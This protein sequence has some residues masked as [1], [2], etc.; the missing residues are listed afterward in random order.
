MGQRA[1]FIDH[2]PRR[3][4]VQSQEVRPQKSERTVR[5]RREFGADLSSFAL[6]WTLTL[7]PGNGHWAKMIAFVVALTALTMTISSAAGA[8]CQFDG[9]MRII[10]LRRIIRAC[11]I[12]GLVVLGLN[13]MLEDQIGRV[14]SVVGSALAAVFAVCGRAIL[15][16][17]TSAR[18]AGVPSARVVLIADDEDGMFDLLDEY[19]AAGFHVVACLGR[20]QTSAHTRGLPWKGT[21][22]NIVD[23]VDECGATSVVLAPNRLCV[24]Y[25]HEQLPILRRRGVTVHFFSGLKG[26]HYRQLRTA[27]IG[28]DPFL[29]LEEPRFERCQ[30]ALKRCLDILLGSILLGLA[31]PVILLA[32]AAIKLEDAGPILF[33]QQR[34]GLNG[35]PFR[36]C[37]LRT[38]HC[39]AEA[40][41]LELRHLN[42]RDGGPLFKMT[43]DPRVTK[44]GCFLRATSID[45]L[46]QL[47]CVLRGDM[48]LVGPRPALPDE[49]VVFDHR[50]AE[51]QRVRPGVTGLWQ[52]EQRDSASF[53]Q[54]RRLDI[55]YVENWSISLDLAILVRTVPTVL[56]RGINAIRRTA[57]EP[58]EL[59]VIEPP[60]LAAS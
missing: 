25:I 54:Y 12:T 33:K 30:Q 24:D 1:Q 16:R 17:Q 7:A 11:A 46:P 10:A 22:E 48:S 15:D 3:S 27:T 29:Y 55:F 47:W 37:K 21:D 8:H 40:R 44:V 41:L 14:Q 42:E 19:G 18:R 32:A 23:V 51:R 26:V 9:Q 2:R 45:E 4:L 28:H 59:A 39:N 52:V 35:I 60:G 36:L 58:P 34:V 6:A 50:L 13:S 5:R 49:A 20:C 53:H 38:M 31:A 43:N 56:G 57:S